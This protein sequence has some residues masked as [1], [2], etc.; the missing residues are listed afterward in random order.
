MHFPQ[1]KSWSSLVTLSRI[2][3]I[4]LGR[5][6]IL[7]LKIPKKFRKYYHS[8]IVDQKMQMILVYRATH[9][10]RYF[11]E[12]L[13]PKRVKYAIKQLFS[14][15]FRVWSFCSPFFPK[16]KANF[17]STLYKSGPYLFSRYARKNCYIVSRIEGSFI[18]LVKANWGDKCVQLCN[19]ILKKH[20]VKKVFKWPL[21]HYVN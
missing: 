21:F 5:Y 11:M 17:C 19:E 6:F 13:L 7:F 9:F 12:F 15:S 18:R 14:R 10:T 3:L 20:F 8:W 2:W 16:V 1:N 4:D